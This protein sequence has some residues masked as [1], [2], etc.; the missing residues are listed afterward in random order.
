MPIGPRCLTR[1][2]RRGAI[3]SWPVLCVIWRSI[4][5]VTRSASCSRPCRNSQ[6][7]L[8]GTLRRT[9]RIA[10]PMTAA[11]PKARRQP[12][13]AANRL[14]SSSRSEASEPRIVPIQYEPPI[15][16][17][18][19]PRTRAG[20]SSSTAEWIAEYSPPTPAPVITR[21]AMNQAKLIEHAVYPHA[22]VALL[23][24]VVEELPVLALAAPDHGGHDHKAGLLRE[25]QDLLDHLLRGRGG[26][27]EAADVA[28]R[29]PGA[30]V[31][32]PQVIVDLRYGGDRRAG[33]VGRGLLVY[34]D[35]RREAVY[36]VHI[37]LVHLP[38]ELPRVG[39]EALDVSPL[40]FGVDGVEGQRRFAAPGDAGHD[41]HHVAR[42]GDG[43]VLQIVLARPADDDLVLG[44]L[45]PP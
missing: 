43:Y 20:I 17:S 11:R 7:G 25:F 2:V 18:T 32:E 6:R 41:Y 42:Q 3:S 10:K 29:T 31:Q 8:S 37:G 34:R 16:R 23:G 13:S 45:T 30:G 12:R 35:R 36:V 39:R 44:D 33:V 14:S 22:G 21:Q 1:I 5:A 38:E 26:H 24:Q 15:T 28:V 9:S 40:A 19:H 27:G 4:S